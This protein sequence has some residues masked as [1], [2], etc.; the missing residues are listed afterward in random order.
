MKLLTTAYLAQRPVVFA[1]P[2]AQSS[3][4]PPKLRGPPEC[5]EG[6]EHG[7][8]DEDASGDPDP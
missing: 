5:L 2:L 3:G 4:E 6:Q 8:T 7:P 1:V